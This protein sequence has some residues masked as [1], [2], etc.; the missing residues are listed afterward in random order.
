MPRRP[1]RRG[2]LNKPQPAFSRLGRA[3]ALATSG[4]SRKGKHY[5]TESESESKREREELHSFSEDGDLSSESS[6]GDVR[7]DF[8]FFDL[9]TDDF[10]GVKVL[11]STYLDNKEWAL[12]I[13]VDL[14]LEPTTMGTVIKIEG[15]KDNGVYGF[16]TAL[17]LHRYKVLIHL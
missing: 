15:D 6:G 7:A 4:R 17:N 14:I 2:H 12:S 5:D 10:H 13:F 8:A 9:K 11:I 1:S 16:N 3:M